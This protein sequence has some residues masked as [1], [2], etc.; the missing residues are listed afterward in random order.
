LTKGVC[1]R[2]LHI[3][4]LQNLERKLKLLMLQIC[5]EFVKQRVMMTIVTKTK[6]FKT[7]R[8]SLL[9]YLCIL[10][11]LKNLEFHI[12]ITDKH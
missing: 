4:V 10:I 6:D 3:E 12:Q 1:T 8:H 7:L 11:S 5:Y 2:F 9:F